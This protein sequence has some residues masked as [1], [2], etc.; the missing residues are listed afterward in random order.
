MIGVDRHSGDLLVCWDP[1]VLDVQSF[2]LTGCLCLEG[3]F[4]GL[5]WHVKVLNVYGP[6]L[7]RVDFWKKL[8]D[9]GILFDPGLILAGDLNLT[10]SAKEIWGHQSRID[11]QAVFLTISSSLVIL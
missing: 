6:Y 10:L 5:N 1:L 8:L 9:L 3:Q 7:E 2:Q 11:S 4:W